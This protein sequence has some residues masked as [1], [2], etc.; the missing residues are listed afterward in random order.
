M[1]ILVTIKDILNASTTLENPDSKLQPFSAENLEAL[2]RNYNHA[3]WMY[4][5][6]VK[7]IKTL[8]IL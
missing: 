1:I 2:S 3:D 8:K 7:T 5:R 4:E 6:H